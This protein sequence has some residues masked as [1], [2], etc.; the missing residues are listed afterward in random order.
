MLFRGSMV[1]L[2]HYPQGD[3]GPHDWRAL[4]NAVKYSGNSP[5]RWGGNDVKPIEWVVIDTDKDSALLLSRYA[6]DARE[7]EG[8]IWGKR[9]TWETCSLR[10]WL[11]DGFL[12]NA[13]SA[14]EAEKIIPRSVPA[15][16]NED[17]D[18]DPGKETVD[19]LFL[20]SVK[21]VYAL[22]GSY[23]MFP[24]RLCEPTTY[25]LNKGSNW[26]KEGTCEWWLRTPGDSSLR[27]ATVGRDGHVVING[28]AIECR[29]ISVRPAMW[30]KNEKA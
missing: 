6:L 30:V 2:G 24:L 18:V 29:G 12:S 1:T 27:A 7:Y 22:L 14:D 11:N 17:Y 19:R 25:A 8:S 15:D 4:E 9:V 10:R 26:C 28:T 20:L 3:V 21:E 16:K 13:F 5:K 23:S